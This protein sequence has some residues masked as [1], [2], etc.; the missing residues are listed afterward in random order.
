MLREGNMRETQNLEVCVKLRVRLTTARRSSPLFSLAHSPPLSSPSPPP[1]ASPLLS[2]PL[3]LCPPPPP[4]PPP[5]ARRSWSRRRLTPRPPAPT[6]QVLPTPRYPPTRAS[7][8]VPAIFFAVS[9]IRLRACYE[10]S[11]GAL[12]AYA[13]ALCGPRA[14]VTHVLA[15]C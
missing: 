11:A 10:M 15:R 12:S 3:L 8:A 9:A 14:D 2:P 13:P 6:S 5:R 1:L 7:Y 4:P